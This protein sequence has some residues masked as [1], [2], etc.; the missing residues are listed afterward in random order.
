VD[1]AT[2]SLPCLGGGLVRLGLAVEVAVRL[3]TLVAHLLTVALVYLGARRLAGAPAWAAALSAAYLAAGPGPRYAAAYF[4]PR[5]SPFACLTWPR[6]WRSRAAGHARP[7]R[8]FAFSGLALGSRDRGVILAA[9]MLLSVVFLAGRK[10]SPTAVLW[11]AGVFGLLGGRTSS[12]AGATSAPPPNPFLK[13]GEAAST[14]RARGSRCSS[15]SRK[16]LP[17]FAPVWRPSRSKGRR[18][19]VA[20]LI[21]VGGFA[22]AFS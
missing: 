8:A 14:R 15:S 6:R 4:G 9:L 18:R 22:L 10:E 7:R 20:V 21:P 12:G 5:S 11:F 17:F 1:G 3:L 2:T 16:G 19:R 13:K